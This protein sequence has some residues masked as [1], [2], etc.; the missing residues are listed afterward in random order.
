MSRALTAAALAVMISCARQTPVAEKKSAEPPPPS[1][2][3]VDSATAVTITGKVFFKGK[4][5]ARTRIEIDEDPQ[6]VKL[7]KAGMF[8]ESVLVNGNGTVSNVFIYVK[9]GLEG[10]Q[11][12]PPPEPVTID[13]KGC[14]FNPRILGVQTGQLI[15]VT[16][17]DP[18]TH[19]IHPMPKQNREW[20]QSQAEGAP[21]L[22]RKFVRPEQMIRVKCN[23]HSWMRAY[24]AAME[25]PY[26]AVTG[27]DGSFEIRNLPPGEYTVEAWQEKLGAQD[28]QVTLAPASKSE[29]VFSFQ[30]M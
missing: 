17:S 19:N 21:P 20:N 13:Q 5:P 12:P 14:R 6:C 30:G 27:P 23:V 15:R 2:F 4:R 1:Y 8:D 28:Q 11:F 24:I 9:K 10:K 18:V 22:E 26:F 25:H 3:K 16:N 7:N 29:L